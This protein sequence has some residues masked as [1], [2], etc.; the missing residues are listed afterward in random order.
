VVGSSQNMLEGSTGCYVWPAGLWLAQYL[1][2]H[3]EIARG[4]R[5]MELGCG[6]GLLGVTLVRCGAREVKYRSFAGGSK[7]PCRLTLS[8]HF[9]ISSC[10]Y[11]MCTGSPLLEASNPYATLYARTRIVHIDKSLLHNYYN[12]LCCPVAYSCWRSKL[13]ECFHPCKKRIP[14]HHATRALDLPKLYTSASMHLYA[15]AIVSGPVYSHTLATNIPRGRTVLLC[16][17]RT[18]TYSLVTFSLP[19]FLLSTLILLVC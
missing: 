14:S 9:C 18:N 19:L 3:P 12:L 11:F 1:L 2:N 8:K 17:I 15:N 7:P 4:K 10:L 16:R 5:C 6:T 13:L